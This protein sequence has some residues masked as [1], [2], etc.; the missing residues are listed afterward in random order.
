MSCPDADACWLDML[1][2][3]VV[4]PCLLT[5]EGTL[6]GAQAFPWVGARTIAGAAGSGLVLWASHHYSWGLTGEQPPACRHPGA[7][8][9]V[10][11]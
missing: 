9:S 6:L 11:W 5:L 4:A 8:C 3:Q 7:I 1:R 2:L 10:V